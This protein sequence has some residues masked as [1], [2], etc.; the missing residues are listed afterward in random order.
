MKN[1]YCVKKEFKFNDQCV[2]YEDNPKGKA[3]YKVDA[4][5]MCMKK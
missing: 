2:I 1:Y 3:Q 4:W 5:A